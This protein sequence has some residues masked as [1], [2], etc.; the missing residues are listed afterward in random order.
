M[1]YNTFIM[2]YQRVKTYSKEPPKELN[3]KNYHKTLE[4]Y[5][6]I[7]I[8]NHGNHATFFFFNTYEC[9]EIQIENPFDPISGFGLIKDFQRTHIIKVSWW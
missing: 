7:S 8:W 6:F 1:H 5:L 9:Q 3:V 2:A 4:I